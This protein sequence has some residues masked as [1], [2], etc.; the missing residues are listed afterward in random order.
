ML[1]YAAIHAL[2]DVNRNMSPSLTAPLIGHGGE[3]KNRVH[4][5]D[6]SPVKNS[7]CLDHSAS[8][9]RIHIWLHITV[10]IK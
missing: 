6:W 7:F 8:C 3:N 1:L 9:E 5:P 2:F 10:Y 4:A